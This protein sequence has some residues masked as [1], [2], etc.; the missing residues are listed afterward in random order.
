MPKPEASA[1]EEDGKRGRGEE[2]KVVEV[3]ALRRSTK[4]RYL[5]LPPSSWFSVGP[6]LGDELADGIGGAPLPHDH[7]PAGCS[8]REARIWASGITWR[9]Q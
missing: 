7:C 4:A 2:E 3:V 1:A 5:T 8:R 9:S 6:D